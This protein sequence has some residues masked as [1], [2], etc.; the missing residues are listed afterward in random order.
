MSAHRPYAIG[1]VERDEWMLCMR[2]AMDACGLPA[3]M[4]APL[5]LAFLR[6][7]NVLRSG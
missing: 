1:D 3:E 7:A 2:R 5:D 4:R 6:M